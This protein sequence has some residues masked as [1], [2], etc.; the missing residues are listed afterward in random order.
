M[1]EPFLSGRDIVLRPFLRIEVKCRIRP[2][3]SH[4]PQ[5]FSCL[6]LPAPFLLLMS[7][8]FASSGQTAMLRLQENLRPAGGRGGILA[9]PGGDP[10]ASPTAVHCP[11]CRLMAS[12]CL[13]MCEADSPTA[14][15]SASCRL[16]ARRCSSCRCFNCRCWWC[17]HWQ[18]E[19]LR[20][21]P[22]TPTPEDRPEELPL[23]A[24]LLLAAALCLRRSSV[25]LTVPSRSDGRRMTSSTGPSGS[26]SR[27]RKRPFGAITF[28][29]MYLILEEVVA[30]FF[31]HGAN[32][33]GGIVASLHS[34]TLSLLVD[35]SEGYKNQCLPQG[36]SSSQNETHK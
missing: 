34:T 24:L 27:E 15:F 31:C 26:P 25:R 13:L 7:H 18:R 32:G 17:L 6:P 11:V 9:A 20:R 10:A 35:N 36:H 22:P 4:V 12:R 1:R 5:H 30:A 19:L 23:L 33:G 2:S 28:S 3:V 14:A 21:T 8:N 29:E 16:S